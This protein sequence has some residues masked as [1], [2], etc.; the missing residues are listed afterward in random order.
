MP[1]VKLDTRKLTT[2]EREQLRRKAVI[3][4]K[5]KNTVPI[6]SKKLGVRPATVYRW[7]D[8]YLKEGPIKYKEKSRGR[9]RQYTHR[10]TWEEW[11]QELKEYTVQCKEWRM[12]TLETMTLYRG[13]EFLETCCSGI[14]DETKY[15]YY[16]HIKKKLESLGIEENDSVKL[17]DKD[18][19]MQQYGEPGW[20]RYR[21]FLLGA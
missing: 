14:G 19:L 5:R 7:I 10:R 15:T 17:Q 12:E 11:L 9:P 3:L 20:M 6:I 13:K 16:R 4:Y 21:A 2:E 18:F 1:A 8:N